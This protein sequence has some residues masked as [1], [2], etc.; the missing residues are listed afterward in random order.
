VR[1]KKAGVLKD[2]M[3][4]TK[5]EIALEQICWACEAGLPRGVS[6]DTAYGNDSRLRTRM[7]A[8][9]VQCVAGIL[10]NTLMWRSG[11]RPRRKGKPLNN[12]GRC[13]EPDLNLGQGNGA[14]SA[15]AGLAH[16]QMVRR[17]SRMAFP[18]ALRV[19]ASVS[20]ITGWTRRGCRRSGC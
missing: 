6:M 2:I 7:T 8:L 20:D 13:D 3:F 16:N 15:E 14:W 9:E 12:T 17:F 10:P 5:A 19:C 4:M 18:R 11:D 1:R